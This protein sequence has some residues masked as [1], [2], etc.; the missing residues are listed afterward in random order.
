MDGL[1]FL[2][3]VR[4]DNPEHPFILYTGKVSEAV[5]SEAIAANV[6]DYP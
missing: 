4:E 3:A 5:T 2:Q 1:E 6:T